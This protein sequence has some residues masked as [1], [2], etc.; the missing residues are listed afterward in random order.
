MTGITSRAMFFKA[1]QRLYFIKVRY[2]YF[3]ST[4]KVVNGLQLYKEQGVLKRHSNAFLE[5]G[6]QKTRLNLSP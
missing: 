6:H 4:S 3:A 2:L 1:M 5:S